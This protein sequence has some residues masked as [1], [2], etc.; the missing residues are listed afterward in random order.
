MITSTYGRA[1]VLQRVVRR[2]FQHQ[3]SGESSVPSWVDIIM[4]DRNNTHTT[5][6]T[7]TNNNNNTDTTTTTTT[8]ANTNTNNNNSYTNK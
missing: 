8:T 3:A 6:N 7:N 2:P 4:H 5:N 1:C